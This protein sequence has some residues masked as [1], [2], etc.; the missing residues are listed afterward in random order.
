MLLIFYLV[1]YLIFRGVLS[2]VFC[3]AIWNKLLCLLVLF[4]FLCSYGIRWIVTC[5]SCEGVSLCGSV[6]VQSPCELSGFSG[7]VGSEVSVDGAFPHG[8]CCQLSLLVGGHNRDGEVEPGPLVNLG[9]SMLNDWHP[10]I[11]GRPSSPQCWS[12]SPWVGFRLVPFPLIVCFLFT[13][14]LPPREEQTRATDL[15]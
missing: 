2:T 7:E 13:V 10:S 5:Y 11:G 1:N 6:P 3:S 15:V 12:K 14:A 4:K 8:V 9:F